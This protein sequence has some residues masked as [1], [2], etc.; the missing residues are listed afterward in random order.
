M[1][2]DAHGAGFA[3][4]AERRTRIKL[5][6]ITRGEDAAAAVAAGV[7]ALGFIFAE[8]S[9]RRIDP[10][11]ARA[12]IM[13]LPPF[14]SA[15]GVFVDAEGRDVEEIIRYCHLTF[16]QLHGEEDPKYCERLRRQSAPCRVIKAFRVHPGLQAEHLAQFAPDVAGFLFDTWRQ[17]VAGGT[18]ESFDWSHISHWRLPRPVILAGGLKPENVA[19]SLRRVRP[20]ALDVNSGVES[21]PGIKDIGRLHAFV[22]EVRRAEKELAAA[23]TTGV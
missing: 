16:A 18:G 21:S 11:Q 23:D 8:K 2:D 19:E 4:L 1:D 7:D 6:G 5:C 13:D 10:D 22:R 12:I 9:P 17:G 20:F 3:P 15:V 14:V